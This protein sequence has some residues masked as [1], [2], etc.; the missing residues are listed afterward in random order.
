MKKSSSIIGILL[1]SA[2]GGVEGDVGV[3]EANAAAAEYALIL[4]FAG[5]THTAPDV[6]ERLSVGVADSITIPAIEKPEC[7]AGVAE[8]TIPTTARRVAFNAGGWDTHASIVWGHACGGT[9]DALVVFDNTGLVWTE[10]GRRCYDKL[11]IVAPGGARIS[12]TAQ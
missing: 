4:A 3:D 1:L 6:T 11:R 8:L 5:C 10:F 2:C 9:W 12:V 7:A